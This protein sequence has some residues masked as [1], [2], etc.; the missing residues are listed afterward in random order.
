MIIKGNNQL[1]LASEKVKPWMTFQD[2]VFYMLMLKL[3]PTII[4]KY[5]I[6]SLFMIN[7]QIKELEFKTCFFLKGVLRSH[8]RTCK[9]FN[10]W[11]SKNFVQ[12]LARTNSWVN[13]PLKPAYSVANK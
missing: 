3:L 1:V 5:F 8:G 4:L 13:I 7:V 6:N 2:T 12:D 10:V 9:I 11:P